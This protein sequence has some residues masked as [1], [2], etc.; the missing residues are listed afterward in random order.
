MDDVLS[1][2]VVYFNPSDFPGKYV[3]RRHWVDKGP[4]R[5]R[6]DQEPA[7][8]EDTLQGVRKKVPNIEYYVR[9][10]RDPEDDP[11]IVEIWI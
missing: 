11:S 7:A 1:M 5:I 2:Y 10:E 6:H 4:P 8:V 9:L 3:I